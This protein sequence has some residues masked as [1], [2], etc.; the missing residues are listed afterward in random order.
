MSMTE[1]RGGR[2]AVPPPPRRV[3]SPDTVG[4]VYVVDWTDDYIQVDGQPIWLMHSVHATRRGAD[5]EARRMRRLA[6][7]PRNRNSS[8]RVTIRYKVWKQSLLK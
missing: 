6:R 7:L 8:G 4:T 3:M 2:R 1:P 5:G